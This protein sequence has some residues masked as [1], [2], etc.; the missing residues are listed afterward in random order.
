MRNERL[1]G[2]KQGSTKKQ[3]KRMVGKQGW[4]STQVAKR[5]WKN[6][7][8]RCPATESSGRRCPDSERVL[9]QRRLRHEGW[10]VTRGFLICLRVPFKRKPTAN[11]LK[12]GGFGVDRWFSV[13]KRTLMPNSGCQ[14]P[15]NSGKYGEVCKIQLSTIVVLRFPFKSSQT[16]GEP[17]KKTEA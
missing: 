8:Q 17:G 3:P 5:N 12:L 1:G 2:L 9:L 6:W 10:T 15:P 7:V 14:K 11:R 13:S 4:L 16:R